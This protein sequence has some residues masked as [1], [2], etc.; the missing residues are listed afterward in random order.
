M[1]FVFADK[2]KKEECKEESK[3]KVHPITDESLR[4]LEK[5]SI[6]ERSLVDGENN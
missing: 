1:K 4:K 6:N 5:L 2:V 3:I